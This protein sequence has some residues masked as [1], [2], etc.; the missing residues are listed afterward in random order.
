ME[1]P[2]IQTDSAPTWLRLEAVP[3]ALANQ[4]LRRELSN[5][6][7]AGDEGAG[8]HELPFP[9]RLDQPVF[10][11]FLGFLSWIRSP[12]F[13]AMEKLKTNHRETAENPESQEM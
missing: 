4:S 8:F 2:V 6:H 5:A 11:S 13:C 3:E 10:Q 9:S 7:A 12:G 1:Q